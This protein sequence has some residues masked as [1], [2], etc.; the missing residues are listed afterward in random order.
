MRIPLKKY[1]FTEKEQLF[2]E[3]NGLKVFLFR[4]ETGIEAVRL[5][6]EKGYLIV[7]PYKGQMIWEAFFGGRTLTLDRV[8]KGE[9]QNVDYFLDSWG[10]FFFH[11]GALR[12]GCPAA[13][14]DHP[15]HGELPYADYQRAEIV[16]GIDEKKG[17]YIGL[18]GAR[19][20]NR[21]FGDC[22]EARPLV[23]V[24][25]GSTLI[26]IAIDIQNL[27]SYPMELMYQAHLNFRAV[28][29]GRIVQSFPW[30]PKDMQIRVT[31]PRHFKV[32]PDY[33]E[34][35]DKLKKDPKYSEILRP[36]DLYKPEVTFYMY[37]A[38][39]DEQGN[40]HLMQVHPDGSADFMKYRPS[41]L[42]H[43]VRWITKFKD[44]HGLG[45]AFPS[46]CNPEG[47]N[48]ERKKGHVKTLEGGQ[49]WH[50][51]LTCGY[52]DPE[53]AKREEAFIM[54]LCR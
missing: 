38:S 29:N 51:D 45:L 35:V 11:C 3:S 13:D 16:A 50:M 22:Y 52:L 7:L 8:G 28:E 31:L 17:E 49:T 39:V 23:K 26:D 47:Y 43:S 32:D 46:T 24:Y 44:Q 33:K 2:F 41:V 19:I 54:E 42:E 10:S 18:T 20:Y 48:A 40:A 6:N 14:D 27:A 34:L 37:N 1:F 21:G 53:E 9:P 12:M 4:Y 36:G 30:D 25:R 5:E 15:L